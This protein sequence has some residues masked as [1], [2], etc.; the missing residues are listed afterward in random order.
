MAIGILIVLAS[1]AV[2][3]LL[4][5]SNEISK[6]NRTVGSTLVSARGSKQDQPVQVA[7]VEVRSPV[8]AQLAVKLSDADGAVRTADHRLGSK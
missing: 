2:I 7:S 3:G 4:I 5:A 1:V 6:E 8:N